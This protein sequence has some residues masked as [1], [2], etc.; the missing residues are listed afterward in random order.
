MVEKQQAWTL[1]RGRHLYEI[2]SR[3]CR[4]TPVY[5]KDLI[6]AVRKI[7]HMMPQQDRQVHFLC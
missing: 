6:H 4:C 3:R 7:G 2:S 1:S 5:G